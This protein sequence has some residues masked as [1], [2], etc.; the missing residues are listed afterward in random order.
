MNRSVIRIVLV[1]VTALSLAAAAS[2]AGRTCS[3]GRLVGAWGYTETGTV[4][5]PTPGQLLAAAVGRYTFDGAG[6][7][8]G[9]QDSSVGGNVSQDIKQGTYTLNEDCTGTLTLEVYNQAGVLQR[10]STWAIV[11]VD[12]GNGMRGILT[13]LKVGGTTSIPATMTLTATKLF[14]ARAFE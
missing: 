10:T 7:F 3:P 9:T 4:I 5:H 12:N 13:S 1:V 8:S 2:A 6:S 14:P 11:V